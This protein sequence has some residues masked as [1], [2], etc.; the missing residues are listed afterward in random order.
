MTDESNGGPGERHLTEALLQAT[1]GRMRS[2]LLFGSRLVGAS[3]DPYSAFD[4]VVVVE[5]Y[6]DFYRRLVQAGHHPRSPRTLAALARVLPPNIVPFTPGRRGG[7]DGSHS[8]E[9]PVAK[10]MIYSRAHLAR[11]LGPR[12][13]DHFLKG[14]MMQRVAILHARTGQDRREVE[15]LLSAARLEAPRWVAPWLEGSF[16]PADFARRMLQVSY[17]GE[18]RPESRDRVE[19]VF[20]VQR[21]WMEATYGEVLSEQV[22]RGALVREADGRYRL[23]RPPGRLAR[24]GTRLYF[25]RSKVRATLRWGKHVLTFPDWL[26]YIQRKVE[27]RTGQRVELTARERKYPLIFLWPK[28]FRVL[29]SLPS[30]TDGGTRSSPDP[31]R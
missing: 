1:D 15:Q 21:E 23:V 12:A 26:G 24:L 13:R 2:V 17:G 8:P 28:V 16:T 19:E 6:E 4:F 14:R 29:R 22:R 27:R 20:E 5:D 18:V 25:M 11:A 3:P 30:T 10:C 7:R 9:G 31:D